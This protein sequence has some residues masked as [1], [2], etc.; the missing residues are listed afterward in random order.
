[1]K[2]FCAYNQAFSFVHL[3]R[4]FIQQKSGQQEG[5]HGWFQHVQGEHYQRNVLIVF[6]VMSGPVGNLESSS[7]H[8]RNPNIR[9]A[10]FIKRS[11]LK[12]LRLRDVI[13]EE[14]RNAEDILK[15]NI[16]IGKNIFV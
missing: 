14:L 1:M 7:D 8:R 12:I 3:V 13:G 5:E 11:E 6:V 16:L 10:F 4:S 2:N 15:C 9:T